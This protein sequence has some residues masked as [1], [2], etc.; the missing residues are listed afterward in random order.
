MKK[1]IRFILQVIGAMTVAGAILGL[2]LMFFAGYWMKVNEPPV[3]ADY[4]LPLAGDPHRL[5]KAA[6]LYQKGYAPVLLISNSKEYPPQP[7]D[8]LQWKMG[9]PDYSRDEYNKR[10]L[11][12]LGAGNARL[13]PFGNGHISTAEEAEALKKYFNGKTPSL[14]IVTSPNH[15]R[16]AKMIFEDVL[17]ECEI[18]VTATEEGEFETWWWKDQISSQKL[19]M[20]F[21]KTAHYMLGGAFRSTD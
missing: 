17:P 3:K 1:A 6:E 10:L 18:T 9:Y 15:T 14:L 13:E 12:L 21:A 19:V 5:I 20:E 16:R 7:I 8:I 11:S 4:I 2:C